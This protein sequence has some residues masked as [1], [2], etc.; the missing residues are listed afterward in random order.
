MYACCCKIIY[1]ILPPSLPPS[2][3]PIAQ[4]IASLLDQRING[5]ENVAMIIGVETQQEF[6]TL[7]E[8]R[9]NSLLESYGCFSKG[10]GQPIII[11]NL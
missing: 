8:D 9:E 10:A 6:E 2:L 11:K 4:A 5:E 3:P 7:I 1:C